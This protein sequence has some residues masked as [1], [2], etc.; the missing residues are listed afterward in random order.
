MKVSILITKA[1]CSII[2]FSNWCKGK[3]YLDFLQ[4]RPCKTIAGVYLLLP[5]PGYFRLK[6]SNSEIFNIAD[7]APISVFELVESVRKASDHL[8]NFLKSEK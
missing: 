3:M 7:E 5:K 8:S 1:S 6:V 2:S 4:N